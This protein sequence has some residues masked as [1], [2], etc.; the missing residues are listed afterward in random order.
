[1]GLYLVLEQVG[2]LASVLSLLKNIDYGIFEIAEEV[3]GLSSEVW[4][5]K[6]VDWP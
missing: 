4:K 1:M 3:G 5:E 2:V 6:S